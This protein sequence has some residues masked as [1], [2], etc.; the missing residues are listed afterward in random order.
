M[1]KK[2]HISL[3]KYIL[4]SK[5][6]EELNKCKKSFYVGSILPDCVPSFLTRKHNIEETLDLLKTEISNV[7][8]KYDVTKGIDTYFC[9]HLGMIIHYV[10]DYFTFPHNSIYPGTMM[11]HCYYEKELKFAF[12]KYVKSEQAKRNRLL[13]SAY[14]TPEEI[15]DFVKS[16]HDEYLKAIK[17]IS[18][19]CHYI[20]ELCFRVVDAILHYF[21][22]SRRVQAAV[23]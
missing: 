1:R 13:E 19:D 5:G 20:V 21:E 3:A 11:E 7:T 17:R 23:M 16:M 22:N 4:E 14:N 12:R 15:V 6:M 10:A 18:V 2:S 8:D 9:R